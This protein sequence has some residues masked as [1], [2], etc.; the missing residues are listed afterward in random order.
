MISGPAKV[1][2]F[3]HAVECNGWIQLTGQ[4]PTDPLDDTMPLPNGVIKQTERVMDNLVIVLRGLEL[5][6]THVFSCRVYLTEFDRDYEAMNSVY[7][8]YFSPD[9][10]PARTCIGVNGLARSSLIEIDAVAIRPS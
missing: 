1:G 10:L 9:R 8:S 3:S 5:N 2:P 4:M 6:L 7:K